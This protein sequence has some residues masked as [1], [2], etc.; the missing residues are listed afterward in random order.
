MNGKKFVILLS[1]IAGLCIGLFG[2]Y[3]LGLVR[4]LEHFYEKESLTQV[5]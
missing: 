1:V 5:F 2:I 3:L 4:S